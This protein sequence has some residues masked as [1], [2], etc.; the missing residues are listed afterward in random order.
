MGR[1]ARLHAQW[2]RAK[3]EGAMSK[4]CQELNALYSQCVD[5]AIIKIPDR[6]RTP[7]TPSEPFIVDIMLNES[8]AFAQDWLGIRGITTK[9]MDPTADEEVLAAL[10]TSDRVTLT[11]FQTLQL[12]WRIARRSSINIKPYIPMMNFGSLSPSE[13]RI[14]CHAFDLTPEEQRAVWNR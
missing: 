4:E 3:P 1:A 6:L 9:S 14:I 10:L 12:A 11:E 5:G 7:P 2:V 8:K 13:K